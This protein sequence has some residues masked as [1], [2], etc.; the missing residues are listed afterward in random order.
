MTE[1]TVVDQVEWV[2]K[3]PEVGVRINTLAPGQAT[4]WHHHS[5]VDDDIFCL[6]DPIEIGLQDPDETRTL[7]PGQRQHIPAGQIHRVVN[8]NPGPVRYLLIQATGPYDFIPSE[9]GATA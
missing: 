5:V 3:T 1:R 4:P 6:A 9:G 7:A 8:R 2:V